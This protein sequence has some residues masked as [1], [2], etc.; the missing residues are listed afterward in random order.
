MARYG[1]V[2]YAVASRA[3]AQAPSG[4]R[5]LVELRGVSDAYPLA[6]KVELA[7]SASL[8]TALATVGDAQGAAVEKPLLERLGL[9]LGDRF[10][11]GNVPI[12]ARAILLAEPDRLARGFRSGHVC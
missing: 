9:R 10:M 5:R 12:V 11:V 4:E 7:G 2:D 6:G 8:A 1:Q 3:M